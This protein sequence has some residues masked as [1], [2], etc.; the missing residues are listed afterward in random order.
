MLCWYLNEPN[1]LKA[2]SCLPLSELVVL[3]VNSTEAENQTGKSKSSYSSSSAKYL[4]L[5]FVSHTPRCHAFTQ[6]ASCEEEDCKKNQICE[7]TS[8]GVSN[9]TCAP[10]FYGDKCE[11]ISHSAP[12]DAHCRQ[13]GR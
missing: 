13:L 1:P 11:G 12:A 7:Y 9:C 10:G 4:H 8:S 6:T 5:Q 2:C 3:Q